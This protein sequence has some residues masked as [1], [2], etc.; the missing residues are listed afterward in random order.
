MIL[1]VIL[2]LAFTKSYRRLPGPPFQ[3]SPTLLVQEMAQGRFS[4]CSGN[5]PGVYVK[6]RAE[7]PRSFSE[8]RR[9]MESCNVSSWISLSS[10]FLSRDA[11][12]L[13]VPC[14]QHQDQECNSLMHHD[15]RSRQDQSK[16]QVASYSLSI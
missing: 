12:F 4:R 13:I 8:G 10:C 1:A 11:G 6:H 5:L 3:T 7:V 14:K 16:F 15:Q 9:G 2:F